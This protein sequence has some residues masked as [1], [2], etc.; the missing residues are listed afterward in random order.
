[1]DKIFL[2]DLKLKTRIGIF[3]WE[4]Q[5]DQVININIEVGTDIKRASETDDVQYSLDYKSLS[6]KVKD[7]VS[8]N[9]HDLIETLIENIAQML[10]DEFDINYVTISISK[11]GA[12]RD[13]QDVGIEIT[14]NKKSPT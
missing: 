5:I 14:R 11:P 8:N 2:R 13:S 6:I 9:Q 4:K 3:E 7:Y 10:L 12:I 1:M